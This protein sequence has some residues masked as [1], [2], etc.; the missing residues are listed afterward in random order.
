MNRREARN[1]QYNNAHKAASQ[2]GG[3]QIHKIMRHLCKDD[4]FYLLTRGLSRIDI[5]RD[6]L[7]ERCEEVQNCPDGY[8]DLWA[9]EHY[10][11]TIITYGK[12]I[13]DILNNPEITVGIFSH[14]KPIAKA[15]L[16]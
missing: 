9:R 12:T 7:F 10:K 2:I 11:S 13:Q 6:W 4:L 16:R 15:F 8:I 3:D 1:N 5:N 14:T